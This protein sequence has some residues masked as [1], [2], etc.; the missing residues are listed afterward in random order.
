M[1]ARLVALQVVVFGCMLLFSGPFTY[2]F[3]LQTLDR[4]F[5][6]YLLFQAKELAA[7]YN[8]GGGVDEHG[9]GIRPCPLPHVGPRSVHS[10]RHLLI[11]D[12]AGRGR[13]VCSDGEEAPLGIQSVLEA[14]RSGSAAF[15]DVRWSGEVLRLVA[16]PFEDRTGRRL[17]MEV[18]SS[19]IVIEGT[20]RKG[21]FFI[22]LIDVLALPLLVAGSY[23]LAREAFA[24]IRRIVQ[25]VEQIDEA[26]LAERLPHGGTTDEV[27]RLV[28]VINHMLG[29]LER[30][31]DAQRI[32][33]S[34][35]SHEIRSPLTALRGEIEVAL[36]KERTA[37]EYRRVL[38]G[39]LEE[40]L[41]LT[42]LA[43]DLMSLAQA[44]AGVFQM[45]LA[46]VDLRELLA[47]IVRRFK[48]RAGEK[49]IRLILHV[50]EGLSV[51][52][53]PDWLGRLVEN[54][55][56]NALI[57]APQMGEVSVDARKSDPSSEP[58]PHALIAVRDTGPG[59]P[60]EHLPHIFD[61]FYRAD[62][63]RSRSQG[64][65]GL[66]LAIAKQIATLHGGKIEARSAVGEG[67]EFLVWLP[68]GGPRA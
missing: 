8:R 67:S 52:G 44:D 41:R 55:V 65:A 61:R 38:E 66:G 49:N 68:V 26:N 7:D 58:E 23:L 19:H 45:R 20:L 18:G 34:D 54:L 46:R 43:E 59:I 63:S 22:L 16:Y 4:D 1:R 15:A 64:G 40:V 28:V 62:Q 33:S 39:S 24:P 2:L 29:R 56:D 5:D 11:Y 31:F 6:D 36:R 57:H 60:A 37:I 50:T 51:L 10:P 25:Q 27:N 32:F 14:S 12:A 35:V 9:I 3:M 53:D 42:R 21:L 47:Q 13:T 30:A 17:V 48:T